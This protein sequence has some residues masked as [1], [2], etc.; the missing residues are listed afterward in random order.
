MLSSQDSGRDCAHHRDAQTTLLRLGC[1]QHDSLSSSQVAAEGL[2][3]EGAE[4][5]ELAD[6]P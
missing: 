3:L 4:E 5:A 2:E 1:G 6:F